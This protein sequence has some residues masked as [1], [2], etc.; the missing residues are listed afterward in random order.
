MALGAILSA[1]YA[2]AQAM[3]GGERDVAVGELVSERPKI[4]IVGAGAIGCCV[5]L[6]LAERGETDVL[7]VDRGVAGGGS[8]GKAAGG[9]RA[10][11]S[12]EINIRFTL[13]SQPFFES[14]AEEIDWRQVGYIF[15]ARSA[16][17]AEQ[18]RRNVELQRSLGVEVEWLLSD[19]LRRRWPYIDFEGVHAGTWCPTDAV[20][21]Q[22]KLMDVLAGRV[23]EAGIEIREGVDVRELRVEGG[24]VIGVVTADGAIE[25][26]ATV[27]AAGVW[28]PAIAATAGLDLPV[29]AMRREI[30]TYAPVPGI[31]ED[32]PFVADF[33]IGSYVRRDEQGFRISGALARDPDEDGDVDPRGA[34]RTLEWGQSLVP[35]LTG[36]EPTGGWSGLTEITPDHHALLGPVSGLEGLIVATGF[37]GHGVMH[38]PLAGQL[39]AEMLLDGEAHTLDVSLLSPTRFAEGKAL[40]ETMFARRHEQGDITASDRS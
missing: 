27:L 30:F 7:V 19:E 16:E 12:T 14:I 32:M 20:F 36:A 31:P 11:F 17:Q 38:A 6:A 5:A 28:S 1:L 24:R 10:Q 37:S 18:F 3:R 22:V 33:D 4:L 15:L 21:D 35:G 8:S 39:V 23:R 9:L 25:A 2:V 34:L 26:E 40:A 29:Q 13:L